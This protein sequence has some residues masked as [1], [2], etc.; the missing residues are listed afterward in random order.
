MYVT[1]TGAR[2]N[3]GDFLIRERALKLLAHFRPDRP[4]L[5]LNAWQ[6]IKDADMERINA[7]KALI[8]CGGPSAR[9][10]MVPTYDLPRERL[11]RIKVPIVTMGVGWKHASG[12]W[13]AI[14]STRPNAETG[15]LLARL[16]SDGLTNSVRDLE[17]KEFL[18]RGGVERVSA[19]GC[20]ALCAEPEGLSTHARSASGPVVISPGVLARREDFGFRRQFRD[21]LDLAAST[22]RRDR[23]VVA[24]H[25]ATSPTEYASAYGAGIGV[26]DLELRRSVEASGFTAVDISGSEKAMI[27]LYSSA[28]LHVGYRVH[29]H[30]LCT[31]LRIPSVLL[32]EDARGF[33]VGRLLGG[34]VLP[35]IDTR[36]HKRSP[37]GR[38][39]ARLVRARS[40]PTE[41][42][43]AATL[44]CLAEALTSFATG[45]LSLY[46][47]SWNRAT[48]LRQRMQA[49][50]SSLP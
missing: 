23:I 43:E 41:S 25:H 36:S 5:N 27:D 4:V 38:I 32:A 18:S 9:A 31:S 39:A 17:A 21:V 15:A 11:E 12:R 37:L 6:P 29:A 7:A 49:F 13:S 24:F 16:A 35:A 3:A 46:E 2:N 47:A 33:G 45:D 8:L 19:T 22:F 10:H 14:A 42:P 40:L 26:P 28:S 44:P 1:L 34:W 48:Q 50:L 30:I 20:P